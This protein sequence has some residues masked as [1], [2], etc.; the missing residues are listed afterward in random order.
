MSSRIVRGDARTAACPAPWSGVTAGPASGCRPETAG[1]PRREDRD[2]EVEILLREAREAGQQEGRAAAERSAQGRVDDAE[3]RLAR[4]VAELAA[5]RGRLRRDAERDVVLLAV[6]IAQRVL[7]R[8]ISTDQEALH[9][10]VKAAL[11]KMEARDL[12][13][14]RVSRDQAAVLERTLQAIGVP[15][16][17]EVI[18]DAG[19]ES[20]G[21]VFETARGSVDASVSTQ[22]DEIQRGFADLVERRTP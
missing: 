18:A 5:Y 8:Q 16:R 14:V 7:H 2:G 20:G 22:L 3:K 19:L 15:E 9:G 13:R 10:L 17:V 21:I 1:T 4:A 11:D 6:E 12:L